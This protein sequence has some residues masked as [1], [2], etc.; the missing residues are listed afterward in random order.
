MWTKVFISV[1]MRGRSN[2]AVEADLIRARKSIREYFDRL[3]EPVDILD[4]WDCQGPADAGRLWYLG[5]AIKK[6]G[7]CEYCYFVKGWQQ[8]NG[9]VAEMEICRLYGIK[10]IEE[11]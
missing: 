6:L 4:N 1:G 3:Y 10:V 5:E 11:S 9:C 8:H 7:D 2:E